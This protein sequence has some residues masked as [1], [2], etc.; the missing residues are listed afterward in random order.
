MFDRGDD[1]IGRLMERAA[2]FSSELMW[3]CAVHALVDHSHSALQTVLYVQS[4]CLLYSL[5]QTLSASA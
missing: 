2:N 5:A 3:R 1:S 4:S